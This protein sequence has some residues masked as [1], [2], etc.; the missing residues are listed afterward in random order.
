MTRRQVIAV[1][2]ALEADKQRLPRVQHDE[3]HLS[4][5]ERSALE[6]IALP[7]REIPLKE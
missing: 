5:G 4:Q 1:R 7:L 2:P 6:W 3:Q